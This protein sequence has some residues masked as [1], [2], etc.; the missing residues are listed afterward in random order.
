MTS[1]QRLGWSLIEGDACIRN[2]SSLARLRRA[3]PARP[4]VGVLLGRL[5]VIEPLCLPAER[6][7]AHLGDC[8]RQAHDILAGEEI[9]LNR[10]QRA[11]VETVY[12]TGL[13]RGY[14]GLGRPDGIVDLSGLAAEVLSGISIAGWRHGEAIKARWRTYCELMSVMFGEDALC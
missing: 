11:L 13:L 8:L 6:P 3:R 2:G 10:D 4:D 1:A 5:L 7:E 14:D 12:E 9:G